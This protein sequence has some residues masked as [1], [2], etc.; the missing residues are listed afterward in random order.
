MKKETENLFLRCFSR[1]L[2]GVCYNNFGVCDQVQ[3]WSEIEGGHRGYLIN[4]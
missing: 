3:N 1:H 4:R 2:G